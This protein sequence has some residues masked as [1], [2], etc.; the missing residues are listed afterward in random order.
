MGKGNRQHTPGTGHGMA[1]KTPEGGG[2]LAHGDCVSQAHCQQLRTLREVFVQ[3][4]TNWLHLKTHDSAGEI[5]IDAE[6]AAELRE[7]LP[8]SQSPF[9]VASD[10]PPRNASPR[11]Y[12]RCEP[13]FDRLNEWLRSK[14][15]AAN[16]P[17]HEMRKEIGA[18][19]ATEHGIYAASRFPCKLPKRELSQLKLVY[20]WSPEMKQRRYLA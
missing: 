16:K 7:F 1:A 12:Y 20:W 19:I 8:A 15:V 13:V 11:P 14:G 17:L 4:E 18:L 3:Q 6:V 9:I 2:E 10:R 5:T